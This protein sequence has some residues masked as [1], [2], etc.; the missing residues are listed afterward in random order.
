MLSMSPAAVKEAREHVDALDLQRC[1]E[2]LHEDPAPGEERIMDDLDGIF[3]GL[4]RQYSAMVY[5]A[6]SRN[7]GLL[8][9]CG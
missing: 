5:V 3:V 1:M 7:Y 6:A 4:I 8:G 2:L 9:H